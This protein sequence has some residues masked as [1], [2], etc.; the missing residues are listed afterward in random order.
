MIDTKE[1]ILNQALLLFNAKGF[2]NVTVREIAKEMGISHG[3]LCYH[4]PTTNEIAYALYQLLVADLDK[5]ITE[6]LKPDNIIEEIIL[7]S[8]FAIEKFYE[9][10]FI[11]LDF[12]SVMRKNEKIKLHYIQ[13]EKY[14][15]L[16]FKAVFAQLR[17]MGVMRNEIF[18]NEYDNLISVWLIVGD[19]WMAHAEINFQGSTENKI[20]HYSNLIF[21]LL[22]PLLTEKGMI[23][24]HNYRNKEIK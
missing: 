12:V 20:E 14:R 8:R 3:N 4:Y 15:N 1:K 13:L 7:S 16:Q 18:P 5:R 10:R 9:Y 19:F 22:L 21:S 17:E 23:M 2:E 6:T 11:M 24:L